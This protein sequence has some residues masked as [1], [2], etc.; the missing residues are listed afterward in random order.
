MLTADFHWYCC[1]FSLLYFSTL[2]TLIQH[3]RT[4]LSTLRSEIYCTTF[5]HFS[6][7]QTDRVI[8][9]HMH[10]STVDC[11]DSGGDGSHSLVTLET[12]KRQ[13]T[14]WR[15]TRDLID[16]QNQIPEPPSRRLLFGARGFSLYY[17]PYTLNT[18]FFSLYFSAVYNLLYLS[19]STRRRSDSICEALDL[20]SLSVRWHGEPFSGSFDLLFVCPA[21][22][23]THL[24]PIPRHGD[25]VCELL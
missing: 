23:Y 4:N 19:R 12:Q 8:D 10:F 7:K 9:M 2:Q 3:S 18:C 6:S 17:L 20:L 13:L 5:T 22:I 21:L 24:S 25:R 16:V 14:R 15:P 1:Y 11:D